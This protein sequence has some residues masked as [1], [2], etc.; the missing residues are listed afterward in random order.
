MS[1]R[2]SRR[3]HG[4]KRIFLVSGVGRQWRAMP[5]DNLSAIL[6]Y[7]ANLLL[8]LLLLMTLIIEERKL[9]STLP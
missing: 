7:A 4:S 5:E 9:K 1:R 3:W 8:I 2:R 6:L